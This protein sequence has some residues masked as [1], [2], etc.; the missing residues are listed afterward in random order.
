MLAV[1]L[2]VSVLLE[3]H[4]TCAFPSHPPNLSFT[5]HASFPES[6]QFHSFWHNKGKAW[7]GIKLAR[8][9]T[10]VSVVCL[11][12]FEITHLPY[13][14]ELVESKVMRIRKMILPKTGDYALKWQQGHIW[15]CEAGITICHSLRLQFYTHLPGNVP[16]HTVG[17]T[18]LHWIVLWGCQKCIG[19]E[20]SPTLSSSTFPLVKEGLRIG[21]FFHPPTNIL[22]NRRKSGQYLD[23]FEYI[24][25]N[26][27]WISMWYLSWNM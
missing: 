1:S 18:T 19:L 4:T 13:C 25:L 2:A 6:G 7:L 23:I 26:N 21:P 11:S 5:F 15:P 8:H 14:T 20:F 12:P 27:I 22:L 17:L 3:P 16:L 24:Q 9:K 10:K